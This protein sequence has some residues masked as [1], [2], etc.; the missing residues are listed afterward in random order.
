VASR[1]EP[2]PGGGLRRLA[3]LSDRDD[4]AWH[5]LAGR[6]A[7]LVEPR[8]GGRVLANRAQAVAGDW[9]LRPVLPALRRA[10]PAVMALARRGPFLVRT[11]V[12]TFYPS[13][14]PSALF[15]ALRSQAVGAGDAGAAAHLLDQWGSEGY[16]GLPVG[17]SGSAVLA[18]A[19]LAGV[20]RCLPFPFLRW[21]DDYLIAVPSEPAAAEA[22]E[23]LD[24]ALDRAGLRRSEPKTFLLQGAGEVRWLRGAISGA[25]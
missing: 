6:I 15:R 20:D 1:W 11:D 8:L 12:A 21:V 19:V 24:E 10:G 5:R 22:I 2:K 3:I 16:V 4:L 13:V 9:S 18:N 25:T 14:T 7:A 17:P 23:R